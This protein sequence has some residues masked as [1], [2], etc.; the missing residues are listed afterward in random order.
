MNA[1][2]RQSGLSLVEVLIAIF[3]LSIVLV[4]AVLSL[5]TS[6]V[7]AKVHGDV[8][9]THY[10]VASRLEQIL[11][12][13]FSALEQ[14]AADAGS[15]QVASTYSESAGLPGRIVVYL[16]AYDGDDADGDGDPF[17]GSDAGIL[18]I[19]VEAEGTVFA[20]ETLAIQG[21]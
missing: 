9:A 5:R 21:T 1:G 11:A 6:I 20:L 3:L 10:R 2:Y 18:W 16:A 17:T 13:P 12:E 19:R 7:G 15:W 8:A 14:A 4:P